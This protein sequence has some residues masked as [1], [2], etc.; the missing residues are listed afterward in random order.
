[1]LCESE[2]VAVCLHTSWD[3]F[4][5]LQETREC[6]LSILRIKWLPASVQ[7]VLVAMSEEQ[8]MAFEVWCQP[9]R[10]KTPNGSIL[11]RHG[12]ET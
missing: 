3:A 12:P 6:T 5:L 1:M 7:H 11:D 8:Q 9:T 2:S 10:K 4:S